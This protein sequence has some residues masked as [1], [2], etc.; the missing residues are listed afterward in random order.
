MK[1]NSN[2]MERREPAGYFCF[3]TRLVKRTYKIKENLESNIQIQM[4]NHSKSYI[5]NQML[6]FYNQLKKTS[7]NYQGLVLF[8]WLWLIL[9]IRHQQH[10]K[11]FI[12]KQ[13]FMWQNGR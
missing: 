3:M 7:G 13:K 6:E 1:S 5:I 2:E 8:S 4:E 11:K 9:S 12:T 10:K